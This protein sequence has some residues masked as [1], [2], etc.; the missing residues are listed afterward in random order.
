[1]VRQERYAIFN[2]IVAIAAIILFSIL[3]PAVGPLRAQSGFALMALLAFGPLFFRRR[4]AEIAGDERDRAIHLRATQITFMVFWSI[5]A[6]GIVLASF[7]FPGAR[8]GDFVTSIVWLAA[9]VLYICH[10]IC[11][12]ILYRIN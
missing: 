8:L 3:I 4:A 6:V 12:L 7:W 1:M 5:L 2:I 9:A 10:S 11:L